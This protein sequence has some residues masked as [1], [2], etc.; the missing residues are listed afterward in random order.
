MSCQFSE[1]HPWAPTLQCNRLTKSEGGASRLRQE[2]K[3]SV[4]H[5]GLAQGRSGQGPLKILA[6]SVRDRR[7]NAMTTMQVG[8]V[9]AISSAFRHRKPRQGSTKASRLRWNIVAVLALALLVGAPG[10][11]KA[12]GPDGQ[13]TW[14]VHISLAPTWFDPAEMSGIKIGRAH[15]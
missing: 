2:G 7:G 8:L 12:A 9:P 1:F 11:A 13:L 14:G 15:V 4:A 3:L 6:F 10:P 5:G